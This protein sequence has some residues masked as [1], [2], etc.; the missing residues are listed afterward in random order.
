VACKRDV[1]AR[2]RDETETER[3]HPFNSVSVTHCSACVMFYM[4]S[5]KVSLCRIE[6]TK[7]GLLRPMIPWRVCLS[8]CMK[9]LRPAKRLNESRFCSGW[10]HKKHCV[11]W[12]YRSPTGEQREAGKTLPDVQWVGEEMGFDTAIVKLL[13]SLFSVSL[14]ML[15]LFKD[16]D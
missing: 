1:K 6:C 4:I 12:G 2:N 9:C 10:R 7:C 3:L 15:R 14:Q 13:G 11:K 5:S 8:V 16:N